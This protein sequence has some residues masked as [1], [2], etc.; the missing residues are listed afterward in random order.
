[1]SI[2]IHQHVV[3]E[4]WTLRLIQNTCTLNALNSLAS[5]YLVPRIHSPAFLTPC[6]KNGERKV[7]EWSL[8]TRLHVSIVR[9][10]FHLAVWFA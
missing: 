9:Q 6:R 4:M 3:I 8:G 1:M 2:D 5:L 10:P 7:G